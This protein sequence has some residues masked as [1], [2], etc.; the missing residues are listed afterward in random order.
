[1]PGGREAGAGGSMWLPSVTSNGL[2][3]PATPPSVLWEQC[4]DS[5]PTAMEGHTKVSTKSRQVPEERPRPKGSMEG[6]RV[7]CNGATFV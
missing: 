6:H 5:G 2:R 7:I 3:S 1:M 4:C